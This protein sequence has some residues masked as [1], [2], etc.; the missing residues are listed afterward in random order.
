MV[1][2]P[3]RAELTAQLTGRGENGLC[4]RSRNERIFLC[5]DP[6]GPEAS[7]GALP[8]RGCKCRV[9][10]QVEC[11]QGVEADLRVQSHRQTGVTGGASDMA[12]LRPVL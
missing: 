3:V 8:V 11:L 10:L 7:G 9:V 12:R 5:C 2:Q 6:D 4:N 1:A